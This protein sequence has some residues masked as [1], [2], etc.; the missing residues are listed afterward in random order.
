MSFCL[1]A[2]EVKEKLSEIE[3]MEHSP[4]M[5][6]LAEDELLQAFVHSVV[7][8]DPHNLSQMQEHREIAVLIAE[9][10][11]NGNRTRWFS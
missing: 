6:H 2:N 9:Y 10:L 4:E 11:K 7:C 8:A 5:S 1:D 3:D